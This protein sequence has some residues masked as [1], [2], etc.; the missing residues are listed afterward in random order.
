[1]FGLT[2][3]NDLVVGLVRDLSLV[4]DTGVQSEA[5]FVVLLVRR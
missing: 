2:R 4:A 3:T 5:Y 1:M